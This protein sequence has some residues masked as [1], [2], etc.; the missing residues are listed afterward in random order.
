MKLEIKDIERLVEKYYDGQSTEQEELLL[1]AAIEDADYGTHPTIRN[2]FHSLK[3]LQNEQGLDQKFDDRIMA[4]IKAR[5]P[6][7][8]KIRK[9]VYSV[10][11][12]AASI[13]AV[14]I[15]WFG[16]GFFNGDPVYGTVTDPVIAFHETRL[17]MEEVS[18]KL[19]KG[20]KPAKES[21][22]KID[23]SVKKAS[24]VKK[25]DETFK[26]ARNMQKVNRAGELLKSINKVYIDLGNS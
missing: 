26:K 15:I 14:L 4:E 22:N 18:K 3:E 9:L 23:S 12:I 20:L 24:S 6:K 19:N 7:T 10:S 16:S 8:A 21:V 25:I 1:K 2:Q 17:A 11:G 13:A 5:S